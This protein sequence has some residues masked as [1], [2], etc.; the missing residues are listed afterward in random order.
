ME[1]LRRQRNIPMVA[2]FWLFSWRYEGKQ[3]NKGFQPIIDAIEAAR[4]KHDKADV[5]KEFDL[6]TLLPDKLS[7]YTYQGS[8]TTPPYT[9]CII[10]TIL[11]RPIKL[12]KSQLDILREI[13]SNNFRS[14]QLPNKR[15]VRSSFILIGKQ[16]KEGSEESS[17]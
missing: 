16:E 3:D 12:C 13:T 2:L 15:R 14:P 9:E 4:Q 17:K 5:S 6:S 10:W 11:R 8:L 1:V 7:Y